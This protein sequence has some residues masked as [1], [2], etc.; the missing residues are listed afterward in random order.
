M[1]IEYDSGY[2]SWNERIWS[3]KLSDKPEVT[4]ID[5]TATLVVPEGYAGSGF[6]WTA[7]TLFLVLIPLAWLL[8]KI[9]R[10]VKAGRPFTLE[11]VR[12]IKY[13]GYFV[14]VSVPVNWLVQYLF[15]R[16]YSSF[17]R[18]PGAEVSGGPDFTDFSLNSIFTGLLILVLAQIFDLGVRLQDDSDLTV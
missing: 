3:G 2:G 1:R 12:R 11:N 13:I 5:G 17:V 16:N 15:A 7:N 8:R 10:E 4:A 6:L 9:L 14:L 18:I